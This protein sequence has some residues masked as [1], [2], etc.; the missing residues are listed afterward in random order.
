MV[1]YYDPETTSE[2]DA[3][4]RERTRSPALR[5]ALMR[6]RNAALEGKAAFDAAKEVALRQLD[7]RARSQHELESAMTSRGFSSETARE[8][9]ERLAELGLGGVLKPEEKLDLHSR[10]I[11]PV[12]D[13]PRRSLPKYS[14]KLMLTKSIHGRMRWQKRRCAH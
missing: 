7:V 14:Q 6:E 4:P 9:I 5:Q 12:R 8:V 1:R 10:W 3:R 11:F 13:F 2:E